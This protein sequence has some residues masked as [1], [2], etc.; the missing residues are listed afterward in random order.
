MRYLDIT[1]ALI[2]SRCAAYFKEIGIEEPFEKFPAL[3]RFLD[4]LSKEDMEFWARQEDL[5]NNGKAPEPEAGRYFELIKKF[6]FNTVLRSLLDLCIAD[7]LSPELGACLSFHLGSGVCLHTAYL[8]ENIAYPSETD[9]MQKTSEAEFFCYVDKKSFPIQYLGLQIDGRILAYLEGD[10]SLNPVLSGSTDLF[11]LDAKDINKPY[12]FEKLIDKGRSFFK[13]GGLMLQVSGSGGRRFI[14]KQIFLGIN[15]PLLIV[16]FEDFMFEVN[17][18]FGKMLGALKREAGLLDSG[19][20]FYGFSEN[21]MGERTGSAASKRSTEMVWHMLFNPIV[22]AKI[23]LIICSDKPGLFSQNPKAGE[24]M[25]LELPKELSYNERLSLWQGFKGQYDLEI[26]PSL[27]AMRYHLNAS[28]TSKVVTF[29]M[30]GEGKNSSDNDST[31]SKLVMQLIKTDS[32]TTGKVTYSDIRL[33][34]VKIQQ[35]LKDKLNDVIVSVRETHRILDEWNLRES[36]PYGRSVS[37]LISGPP[38][39]GK[40]MTANAIAG[41]LGMPLYHVNLSNIVD[42]YIGETEKNLERAF[43]FAEKTNAV[44]FFD[45]ADALFGKRS[46]VKDSHD[47]YANTEISYLLQRIE[48]YD[49]IVIL[50]TNIKGNMDPAFLRRIR[51]VLNYVNPDESARYAIWEACLTKD[52]PHEDIDLDYLASQFKDFTGSTIKTVFLNA[53]AKASGRNEALSMAHLVQAIKAELEKGST[54]AFTGDALG[55]YAYLA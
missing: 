1:A 39:T 23:P 38:G 2:I 7:F 48:S 26:D 50:A 27:F 36:Y 16:N 15:R 6:E 37:L 10:D 3:N 49:G 13:E 34:D 42:K 8:L 29:Y 14:A 19:I 18:D 9:I 35:S 31:F 17:K 30:E 32:D 51:Y 46:E 54:M 47:K 11:S 25:L 52:V 45:E 20:C 28:E 40:T 24:F 22:D 12:I 43:A 5:V 4:D 44:L 21:Y 41:E 55:K 33:S 53:C